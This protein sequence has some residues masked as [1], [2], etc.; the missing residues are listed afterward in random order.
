MQATPARIEA[1]TARLDRPR[2]PDVGQRD[3]VDTNDTANTLRCRAKRAAVG[4]SAVTDLEGAGQRFE[5]EV[6]G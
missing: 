6:E 2:L 3:V 5:W 4:S 1:P